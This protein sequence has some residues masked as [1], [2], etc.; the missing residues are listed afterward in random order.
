MAPKQIKKVK[1]RSFLS[2]KGKGGTAGAG[3]DPVKSMTL[4]F[5]RLGNTVEDIGKIIADGMAQKAQ[6]AIDAAEASRLQLVKKQET[7]Y[8]QKLLADPKDVKDGVEKNKP[9][10]DKGKWSWL[11]KL[12]APFA[13]FLKFAA[14]WFVLDFLSN[15]KNKK[16]ISVGFTIIGGWF[17]ILSKVVLTSVDFIMSAFGEKNPVIGALK[18]VGG[19]AGLF[20]ADRILKPWKLFGDAN[21]LRK[22]V[23]GQMKRGLDPK[24]LAA[25]QRLGKWR[26]IRRMR[27]L[28]SFGGNM[29]R[30]GRG[31]LR[32]GGKV[33]AGGGLSVAMGVG[34][35]FRRKDEGAA[36]AIG[37]GAGATIGGLAM[38]ALLTPIL[39]PFGPIVGQFIGSFLGEHIGAF[40][41]D[42]IKPLFEPIKRVFGEILMPILKSYYEGPMKAFSEFWDSLIPALQ[43]VWDFLKPFADAAIEK[44]QLWLQ[45]P[46]I[47]NAIAR[48][49]RFVAAA[50]DMVGGIQ[51]TA[52]K[53]ANVFGLESELDTATRELG[54]EQ[55]T[56]REKERS[57]EAAREKLAWLQTLAADKGG[58]AKEHWSHRYTLD[59]RIA[60]EKRYIEKLTQ[61]R[62]DAVTRVENEQ[63]ELNTLQAHQAESA[64]M[65]EAAPAGHGTGSKIFPLPKGQFDGE[66]SS[67]FKSAPQAGGKGDGMGVVLKPKP[68]TS[69]TQAVVAAVGGI[70]SGWNFKDGKDKN[71]QLKIEAEGKP[72]R[73]HRYLHME[74]LVKKGDKV[75]AGQMIGRLV[76]QGENTRL[77]FSVWKPNWSWPENPHKELPKLFGTPMSA[78]NTIIPPEINS[79]DTVATTT[80]DLNSTNPSNGDIQTEGSTVIVQPIARRSNGGSG[81]SGSTVVGA[82]TETNIR[83]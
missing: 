49:K 44:F 45:N 80:A 7:E 70:I 33:L 37:A 76:D 79:A 35:A 38:S 24:K 8:E 82:S 21:R 30:R 65:L 42:A 36:V 54:D 64:K 11:Q 16:I 74:P 48:L 15:P 25:R 34:A 72:A 3:N 2:V 40:L 5:N 51:S 50:G 61:A 57:L 66:K 71:S 4:A 6:S 56:V 19:I 13:K 9:K 78:E 20:L 43:K 17:K 52:G 28:R 41:G 46:A 32:G 59:E 23:Q 63:Q 77:N 26:N 22:F 10:V 55:R 27:R 29:A 47:K 53:I 81:D 83:G 58:D 39:G 12:L 14:T 31:L 62:A 60:E 67:W 73:H 18:L 68:D 1:V 69:L 75:K